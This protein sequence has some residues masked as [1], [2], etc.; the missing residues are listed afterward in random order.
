[1]A[2]L[3]DLEVGPRILPEIAGLGAQAVP[4]LEHFLCGR[5]ES[6]SQP[7]RLAAAALGTIGNHAAEEALRRAIGDS[8]DRELD[9]VLQLAEA[10]VLS[11][12]ADALK[13]SPSD[14]DLLCAALERHPNAGIARALGRAGDPRAIPILVRCLADATAA[15][16]AGE[17][18]RAFGGAARP[19]LTAAALLPTLHRGYEGATSVRTRARA[20]ELLA[21][22]GKP[23][24]DL[25]LAWALSDAEHEVRLAAALALARRGPPESSAAIPVLLE[26]LA[27]ERWL[28]AEESAAALGALGAAALSDVSDWISRAADTLRERGVRVL[29]HVPH[30]S[31]TKVL[32]RLASDPSARVRAAVADMLDGREADDARCALERLAGDADPAVQMR[33]PGLG[34]SARGSCSCSPRASGPVA[35]TADAWSPRG[36]ASS[37][38]TSFC[39]RCWAE[40]SPETERCPHCG[41]DAK[42]RLPLRDALELALEARDALT[43]RRAAY[44]LGKLRHRRPC[45]RSR[46]PSTGAIRMWQQK[47]PLHSPGSARRMRWPSSKVR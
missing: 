21:R 17:A 10:E 40:I 29:R 44:L 26:G 25:P 5:S 45:L 34:K 46:A 33:A 13:P 11:A 23:A 38:M 43:A 39:Q 15:A 32:A 24:T 36:L 28:V 18:L 22:T 31:A 35:G 1:V 6:V 9:P 20:I 30:Q 4:A 27:D 3:G 2:R 42:E 41:A 16:S 19:R 8:L 12:M 7:R 37:P 47:R 14:V